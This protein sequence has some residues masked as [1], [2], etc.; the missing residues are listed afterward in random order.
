MLGQ[1]KFS[2][3]RTSLVAYRLTTVAFLLLQLWFNPWPWNFP[4]YLGSANRNKHFRSFLVAEQVKDMVL[5]LQRLGCC[6]GMGSIP[7]L[8]TSTCHGHC[9]NKTKQNNPNSVGVHR[10]RKYFCAFLNITNPGEPVSSI[11][12]FFTFLIKPEKFGGKP[13]QDCESIYFM[14]LQ[15][16]EI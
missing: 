2:G 12:K 8:G 1:L 14:L 5:L 4:L 6:C 9:P 13:Q 11:D 10:R 15:N 16:S 7:G 3:C